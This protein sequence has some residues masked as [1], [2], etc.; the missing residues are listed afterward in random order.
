MCERLLMLQWWLALINCHIEQARVST[1]IESPVS[2]GAVLTTP[3][4]LLLESNL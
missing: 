2:P 1:R 4:Q 3:P